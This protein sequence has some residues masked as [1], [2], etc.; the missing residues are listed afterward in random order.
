MSGIKTDIEVSLI[1]Q[2][3][4]V[5]KAVYVPE[6]PGKIGF[7]LDVFRKLQHLEEKRNRYYEDISSFQRFSF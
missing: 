1:P 6:V 5:Y 7:N 4:N 2:G 3:N